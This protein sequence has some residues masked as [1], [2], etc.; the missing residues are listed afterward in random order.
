MMSYKIKFFYL[1]NNSYKNCSDKQNESCCGGSCSSGVSNENCCDS[2][3]NNQINTKVDESFNN[4]HERL[5]EY[6]YASLVAISAIF[7]SRI[8]LKF[9]YSK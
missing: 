5:R 9:F 7:L 1:K 8:A 2:K 4:K 6:A 3:P